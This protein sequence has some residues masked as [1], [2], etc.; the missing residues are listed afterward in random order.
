MNVQP[1]GIGAD[2]TVTCVGTWNNRLAA[3]RQ[4]ATWDVLTDAGE[5]ARPG[6][7]FVTL[8][9][10]AQRLGVRRLILLR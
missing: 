3:G 2:A 5:R 6:L 7:Y 1:F 10:N 8:E 4:A 9:S